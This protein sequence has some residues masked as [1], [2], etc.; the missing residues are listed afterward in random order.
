M[1]KDIINNFTEATIAAHQS[2]LYGGEATNTWTSRSH[3][4]ELLFILIY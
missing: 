3:Q 4:A 2:E 1:K